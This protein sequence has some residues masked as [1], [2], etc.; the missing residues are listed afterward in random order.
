MSNDTTYVDPNT[1]DLD[2]FSKLLEGQAKPLENEPETP[3]E[4]A[5]STEDQEEEVDATEEV[6]LAPEETE[7]SDDETEEEEDETPEPREGKKN[8]S[9]F[10]E[11]IN[12][13][14]AKAREAERRNEDLAR[15]LEE[16]IKRLDEK[17]EPEQ[18][19]PTPQADTGPT[20]D[21]LNED[22]TEKYPLGEF[23]PQFIRD[24]T[25]FTIKKEQEAAAIE[26]ETRRQAEEQAAQQQALVAEWN[27]KL[28][29]AR[30]KY[31]DL[32]EKNLQLATTFENLDPAYGEYLANTIM[33]MDYGTE[34]LYYLGNN[35]E[36]AKQIVASGPT[37]ATIA[38]G[39]L[40]A[41]LASS[42]EPSDST[43]PIKPSKAPPPPPSL[44]KGSK[45][46]KLQPKPDTDDLEDFERIFFKKG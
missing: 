46:A 34:V 29:E 32:D 11:R 31:V 35:V 14:T 16:A 5:I 36:E 43:K 37:R 25:R 27:T 33:S 30:Q 41:Q 23:D 24:L 19:A 13:L 17:R 38:L 20:P 9:R 3:E 40:E 7:D 1:D 44:N 15:K 4:E 8:K 39:R 42:V 12:E 18:K 10:Q 6:D 21:D 28:D 2:A 26:A 45:A 22:G